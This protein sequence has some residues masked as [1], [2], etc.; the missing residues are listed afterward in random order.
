MIQVQS[1]LKVSLGENSCALLTNRKDKTPRA[2]RFYSSLTSTIDEKF[3]SSRSF[4]LTFK[5]PSRETQKY[6]IYTSWYISVILTKLANIHLYKYQEIFSKLESIA[7]AARASGEKQQEIFVRLD[8]MFDDFDRIKLLTGELELE[9]LKLE[10]IVCASELKVAAKKN[11]QCAKSFHSRTK[12]PRTKK[13]LK[14]EFFEN[15]GHF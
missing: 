14:M 6:D 3:R 4:Y 7:L 15:V 10:I 2:S 8:G 9:K 12:M 1:I 5:H 11:E 13:A